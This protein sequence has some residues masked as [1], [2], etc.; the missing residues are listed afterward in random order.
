[1]YLI[2]FHFSSEHDVCITTLRASVLLILMSLCYIRMYIY[3][4]LKFAVISVLTLYIVCSICGS[5]HTYVHS[6]IIVPMLLLYF[7]AFSIVQWE[8]AG[9]TETDART[10]FS[11]VIPCNPP[12]TAVPTP[13]VVWESKLTTASN[14]TYAAIPT[15][16]L[17]NTDPSI[18]FQLTP[19][20][21]LIIHKL[22]SADFN[23]TY[24]C[25]VT[26]ANV[27]T[28]VASGRTHTLN[29]GMYVYSVYEVCLQSRVRAVCIGFNVRTYVC[30]MEYAY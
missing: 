6:R 26:N 9:S 10:G 4:C 8:T 25:S 27:H 5:I 17:T 29:A 1:M 19:E 11:V 12:S 14:D 3:A 13:T 20:G 23:R 24:R 2:L 21:D 30:S 28:T 22:V 7:T 15:A 18:R 16:P